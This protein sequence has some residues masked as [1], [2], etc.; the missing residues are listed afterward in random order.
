MNE[1]TDKESIELS[2]LNL[3]VSQ[4]KYKLKGAGPDLS[5]SWARQYWE[6]KKT[7][8][9]E[10]CRTLPERPRE[11]KRESEKDKSLSKEPRSSR[12][13]LL[14]FWSSQFAHILRRGRRVV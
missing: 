14:S 11:E 7:R 8:E 13:R 5:Y 3:R 2:P 1:S 12:T 6:F 9:N 10:A 4:K